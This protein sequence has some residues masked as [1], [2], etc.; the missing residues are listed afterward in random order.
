MKVEVGSQLRYKGRP[1]VVTSVLRSHEQR[2]TAFD[3]QTMREQFSFDNVKAMVLELEEFH[4]G[5]RVEIDYE[6]VELTEL[7]SH[8][9]H[10]YTF[11][12][13]RRMED[14]RPT[15]Q[16]AEGSHDREAGPANSGSAELQGE[17]AGGDTSSL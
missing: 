14:G 3:S 11:Y 17:K 6:R 13:V 1:M 7:G 12:K 9:E 2:Y 10:I 16:T 15:L 8:L 4:E 5:E